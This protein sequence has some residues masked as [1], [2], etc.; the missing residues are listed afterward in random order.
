MVHR[1]RS[2]I[3]RFFRSLLGRVL[4][5]LLLGA[6]VFVALFLWVISG[7]DERAA[8][9]EAPEEALSAPA[10]PPDTL[11]LLT[12][13]IA[14]GRGPELNARNTDGGNAEA[15]RKRLEDIGHRIGALGLDMVFLQEVDF[16]TWWSHGMDQA[17]IIAEAAGFPFIVR[18][19][20]FDTG[21][22]LFRRYDFGNALL[23]RLP[24]AEA[25]RVSL[26]AFSEMEALFAG[27]HD[28]MLA[29]IQIG[30]DQQILILGAHLEVRSEEAR[31]QAAEELIRVQRKHP[32]PMIL[33][34]DLNSTPPGFPGSKTSLSGQNT[35]ELLES[36]GGFQRRPGRGQA[37]H[38]D[39][40]FPTVAPRRIIDWILAD[41]NW[42]ILE[43]KVLR[44]FQESD[45]LP[46]MATLKRR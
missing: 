14:H 19:R 6:A 42:R 23:S 5:L 43:Y 33:L 13:N 29:T 1:K 22:P 44:D 46:V 37:T 9:I 24:I 40:T 10:T 2:P 8:V 45:H 35:I 25:E 15:K 27:N 21:L 26:P 38:T 34:G 39:F 7:R 4:K 28:A 30:E 18:Q 32:Q 36:F 31:V 20:N 17:S 12:Y 11:R 3:N 41:R 16:N